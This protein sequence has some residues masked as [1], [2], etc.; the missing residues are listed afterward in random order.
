VRHKNRHNINL[1]DINAEKRA[2]GYYGY[3][4]PV[5]LQI[6]EGHMTDPNAQLDGNAI[7]VDVNA[8]KY[9]GKV[10]E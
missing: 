10:V 4:G 2:D 9:I 1:K 6:F 7:I 5:Q 8:E 3:E